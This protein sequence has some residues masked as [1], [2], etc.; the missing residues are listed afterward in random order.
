MK[1]KNR[2][3]M[4]LII[5]GFVGLWSCQEWGEMD[6]AAGNQVYPKLVL[7][8][9][10]EFDSGFSED[11]VLSSYEGGQ[12]PAIVRDEFKGKVAELSGGYIRL[13]NPLADVSLQTGASFTMWVK[14]TEDNLS[15]AIFSF[16]N[17]ERQYV[18]TLRMT[19]KKDN[20]PIKKLN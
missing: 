9:E 11:A 5:L 20:C 17:G 10:Y 4:V 12:N 19:L 18:R 14:T 7:K 3:L 8:G 16:A 13:N 1:R 6:P 2:S 15:G